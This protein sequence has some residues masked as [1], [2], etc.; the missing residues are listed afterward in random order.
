MTESAINEALGESL[1]PSQATTFLACPAKWYF[2]YLLG[3]TEPPTDALAL[4]K[5]FHGTLARS[6]R[7]R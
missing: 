1:S 5:A 6:F 4:G 2:R 7:Q 3:L